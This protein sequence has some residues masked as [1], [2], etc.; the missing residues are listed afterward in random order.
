MTTLVIGAGPAA[1]N[2]LIE[3]CC[4]VEQIA[5]V[6][7]LTV[8]GLFAAWREFRQQ[9]GVVLDRF[10]WSTVWSHFITAGAV[11]PGASNSRIVATSLVNSGAGV[12]PGPGGAQ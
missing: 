5:D 6:Y 2:H 12:M 11:L 1:H 3:G 10:E 4:T 9:P 7:G 8:N